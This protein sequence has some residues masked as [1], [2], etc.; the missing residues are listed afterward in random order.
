MESIKK[1]EEALKELVK[2]MNK[3]KSESDEFENRITSMKSKINL[4]SGDIKVLEEKRNGLDSQIRLEKKAQ[5][6]EIENKMRLVET[7]KIQ[8]EKERENSR[9]ANGLLVFREAELKKTQELCEAERQSYIEK[10]Q[11]LEFKLAKHAEM[12]AVLK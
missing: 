5:L 3:M 1:V 7:I 8:A 11:E 2:D 9:Q 4:L 12:Q 6:D 10:R